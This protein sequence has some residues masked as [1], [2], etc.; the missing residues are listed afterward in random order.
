MWLTVLRLLTNICNEYQ[1]KQ[2]ASF[3]YTVYLKKKKALISSNLHFDILT[4]RRS[5]LP[6][7]RNAFANINQ[8]R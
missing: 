8:N 2:F 6:S 3:I 4:T 5:K 7:S 1:S